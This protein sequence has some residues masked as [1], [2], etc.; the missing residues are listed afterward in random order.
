MKTGSRIKFIILLI[1]SSNLVVAQLIDGIRYT[2]VNVVTHRNFIDVDSEILASL[3]NNGLNLIRLRLSIPKEEFG[4]TILE[5]RNSCYSKANRVLDMCDSLNISVIISNSDFP[6]NLDYSVSMR[7]TEKFWTCKS[8]IDEMVDEIKREVELFDVHKC[9][10]GYDF[11]S[12][13]VVKSSGSIY[14]PSNWIDEIFPKILSAVRETSSN[15]VLFTPGPF[16]KPTNYRKFNLPYEDNGI[17]YSFH[18]YLPHWYTHQGIKGRPSFLNYPFLNSDSEYLIKTLQSAVHFCKEYNVP[19]IVGEYGVN[20]KALGKEV[21]FEDLLNIF[22]E[23]QLS[24]VY[25]ALNGW[26]G[27]TYPFT[28]NDSTSLLVKKKLIDSWMNETR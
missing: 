16:G 14:A 25:Q 27:W 18:Y 2:G 7:Q 23:N 5:K 19:M 21:Y 4:S 20:E 17:I 3:K 26:Y 24:H 22:D 12:E 10:L 1:L 8:C 28:D 13:P 9:I 6:L 15:Y 11:M